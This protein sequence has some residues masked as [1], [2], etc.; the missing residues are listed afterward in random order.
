MNGL[1]NGD[2][3]VIA[4]MDQK[5]AGPDH[6]L[7]AS[8]KSEIIPVETNKEGTLTKRSSVASAKQLDALVDYV[9]RKLKE[10]GKQILSGD[11]RLNPFRTEKA[12]AC[13]YCEYRSVCGFDSKL[14]EHGYRNLNKKSLEEMKSE[15]WGESSNGSSDSGL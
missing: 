10:D 14:P 3:R 4:L 13:D 11:T 1:V 5:L 2:P 15:I 6:S 12:T 7:R 9:N 8:A